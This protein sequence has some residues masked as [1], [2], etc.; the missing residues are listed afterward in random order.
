MSAF[1]M[2]L[3]DYPHF[4]L[5]EDGRLC[6]TAQHC[7]GFLRL[8]Y[9]ARIRLGYDGDAPVYRCRLSRVHDLDR[10]EVSVTIPFD[11]ARPWS[12]SII[13]SEPDTGIEMTAH[14]TLTSL[15]EDHLT[16]TATLP[17]TLLPIRDQE[18]TIWQQRLAAVSDLKGPHF[19]AGMTLLARYTQYLANLQHN[20]A[21]TG[22]QQ[23]ARLLAYEDSATAATGE[24]ERL[25]HENAI[26]RNSVCPPSE[27]DR[28]LKEV[29]RRLSNAEHGWNHT[30]LLLDIT[31][32]EVETRTH[33]IIHL[34]HHV[35]AQDTELEERAETIANL[36]QQLLESQGQAPP[37]PVNPEEIDATSGID[38][39][40]GLTNVGCRETKF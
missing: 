24:I 34:E 22:M 15:C 27:Q 38:G 21:R 9:D 28:E 4:D 40:L 33:G 5:A 3:N 25:R 6:S 35:E 13:D 8:L 16:A 10:C 32:E 17:I 30:R 20:I 39:G 14:I 19:H 36:E 11:P 7:P 2:E 1:Q 31:R 26:L 18:N 23:R 12:G 29:Y 37:E